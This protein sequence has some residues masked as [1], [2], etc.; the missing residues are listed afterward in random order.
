MTD[1][2]L[3]QYGEKLKRM[4]QL[5][6]FRVTVSATGVSQPPN[7]INTGILRA[8]S[9]HHTEAKTFFHYFILPALLLSASL[10]GW[11]CQAGLEYRLLALWTA[12]EK[13]K[14]D[15][16]YILPYKTDFLK[17]SISLCVL[18]SDGYVQSGLMVSRV[19]KKKYYRYKKI[20]GK[21]II[22]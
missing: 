19:D 1:F 8:F 20:Q 5:S 4:L 3:K 17:I 11:D 21:I 13:K 12:C 7:L 16:L 14:M 10:T 15:V 6:S 22:S 9:Q 2:L 18:Y